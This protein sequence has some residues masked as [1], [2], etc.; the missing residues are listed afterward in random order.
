[1]FIIV[2]KYCN[3]LIPFLIILYLIVRLSLWIVVLNFKTLFQY[4]H[5]FLFCHK[6]QIKANGSARSSD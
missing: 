1:M 4:L 2:M 5:C 3:I 6:S